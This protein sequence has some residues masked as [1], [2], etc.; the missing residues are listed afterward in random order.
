MAKYLKFGNQLFN[1]E[2]I[3][4]VHT[5]K[6][7]LYIWYPYIMEIKYAKINKTTSYVNVGRDVSFSVP[8][9]DIN[10]SMDFIYKYETTHEILNDLKQFK[11][12]P[13]VEIINELNEE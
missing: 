3:L 6:S 11:E 13:N 7:F 10:S 2:K 5:R 8:I 1:K 9:E 12:C 4:Q